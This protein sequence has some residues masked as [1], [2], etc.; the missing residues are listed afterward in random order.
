MHHTHN[1]QYTQYTHCIYTTPIICNIYT[2]H[3]LYI[4]HTDNPLYIYTHCIYTALS[5]TIYMGFPGGTSGK[6]PAC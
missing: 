3:T 6:E 4:H 5:L 2:V 1:L